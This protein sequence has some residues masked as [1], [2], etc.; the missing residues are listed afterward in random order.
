MSDLKVIVL[1][2]K[3]SIVRE[4]LGEPATCSL[5]YG[6]PMNIQTD[7]CIAPV[8]QLQSWKPK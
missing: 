6:A 1:E 5:V 2:K 7:V 3:N 8:L 4:H